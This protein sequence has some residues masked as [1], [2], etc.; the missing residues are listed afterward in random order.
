MKGDNQ[1]KDV[2]KESGKALI[3]QNNQINEVAKRIQEVEAFLKQ[4][5]ED[6]TEN[7]AVLDG[8]LNEADNLINEINLSNTDILLNSEEVDLL[9]DNLEVDDTTHEE[10]TILSEIKSIQGSSETNWDTYI[11]DIENYGYSHNIDLTE[12]PFEELLT[13]DQRESIRKTIK[14]DYTIDVNVTLDK[15]DYFIAGFSGVASG[16]IDSFFVGMPGSSKLG[17]LTNQATDNLVVKFAKKIHQI[18]KKNGIKF[19]KNSQKSIDGIAS[20]IGYLEERYKVVYDA[21]YASDLSDLVGVDGIKNKLRPNNHHLLS[22]AH[23]PDFIGLFFSILD[24]F[25]GKTSLIIDGKLQ[26][27]T[28]KGGTEQFQLQGDTFV[29]KIFCG[30]CNWLGHIMSDIAGS[31]GTRGHSN[32][33]IG[34]GVAP[35]FYEL[36]LLFDYGSFNVNG[37]QKSFSQLMTQVYEK[38]YD[39]RFSAATAIPVVINEL[40]IRAL[41]AMK[42]K[43]YHKRDWSESL[44]FGNKPELRRMLLIGYG[45]LCLVDAGD[46]FLRSKGETLTFMLHI[47][48]IAWGQ[49]SFKALIEVRAMYMKGALDVESMTKDL[50]MEWSRLYAQI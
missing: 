30:F 22:L 36:F 43:F 44:P 45:A 48:L 24:Q 6:N 16:L 33:R 28:R 20:A 41:W 10:I 40:F 34:A 2:L 37:D 42:S 21:R 27:A 15:L 50:D 49:F 39:A 23:S 29:G 17:N 19:K 32:G 5:E 25:T 4:L 46:A 8:L 1:K 3:V 13:L 31:S 18:D 12:D 38:G 14:D 26:R 35:G 7:A 9:L 11:S 47:N